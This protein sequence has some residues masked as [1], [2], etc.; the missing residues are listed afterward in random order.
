MQKYVPRGKGGGISLRTIHPSITNLAMGVA[1]TAVNTAMNNMRAGKSNNKVK[2]LKQT[3]LTQRGFTRH[4]KLKEDLSAGPVNKGKGYNQ[5]GIV[6]NTHPASKIPKWK[7]KRLA[8]FNKG[9]VWQKV[10]ISKSSRLGNSDNML[11]TFR[12]PIKAPEALDGERV[13]SMI[14]SPYMSAYSGIHTT[15]YRKVRADGTDLDHA[16]A[17]P[18]DVIQRKADV[19]RHSLPSTVEA[20]HG[21]E[22]VYQN[23]DANHAAADT[24]SAA[25]LANVHSYYNHL[26]KACNIDLVF[27]AS[28]AFP[29]RISV[30]VIRHIQPVAPYTWT[31]EDKQQLLN[32]LDNKGLEWNDYKVEFSKSF[33]LPGLRQGK[34]PPKFSLIKKIKTNFMVTNSFSDNNTAQDQQLASNNLLG[35]GLKRRQSEVADGFVSG[36]FYVLI[37]YR[38]V[39]QPQQFTYSQVLDT[40]ASGVSTASVELPFLSE[41][42]FD[43]PTNAGGGVPG[44]GIPANTEQGDERKATFY[45][46]GS[47]QYQFGLEE[48]EQAVPSIMSETSTDTDYKKTQSLNIDPT[49]FNDNNNGVYTQSQSHETRAT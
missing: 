35:L 44:S 14:F 15:F 21:T 13:Q 16:T 11:K 41:E 2:R 23:K 47:L 32:N 27:M 28:R 48:P 31:T 4:E 36:M 39:Q 37:K 6:M 19:H 42:S 18:L 10:L 9:N 8:A 26:V 22:I 1:E 29:V 34:K 45:V 40:T 24:Q 20:A 7:R 38:K 12:Y 25:A 30:S 49:L 43:V 5:T 33:T 3:K 17:E 46:H